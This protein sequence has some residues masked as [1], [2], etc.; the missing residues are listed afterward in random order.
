MKTLLSVRFYLFDPGSTHRDQK[1]LYLPFMKLVKSLLVAIIVIALVFIL[2]S[3]LDIVIAFF[4]QRFYANLAFIVTFGVGGIFA[5]VFGYTYGIK[6]APIKNEISRWSLIITF[7]LT[8]LFFFFFLARL[9]G[10]E[11]EPAFKAFGVTLALG[12]LLFIKGK[13]DL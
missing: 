1:K 11:Y 7:I 12:S 6:T 10:G 4:Y 13:V 9:E 8:G 2:V 5:A 3:L